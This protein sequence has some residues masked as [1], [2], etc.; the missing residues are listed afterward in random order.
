MRDE[1]HASMDGL[2]RDVRSAIERTME[3]ESMMGLVPAAL[4][5]PITAPSAAQVP[6]PSAALNATA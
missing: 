6:A 3:V 4:A 2:A 1:A 5:A